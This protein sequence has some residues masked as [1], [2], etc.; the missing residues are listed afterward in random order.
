METTAIET[1][2][3]TTTEDYERILSAAETAATSLARTDPSRRAQILRS[4]ADALDA[5]GAELVPLAAA[6]SSLP[7]A[8]LRG[9]V[10]RTTMQLRM[11]ADVVE[12][13]SW[14]EAIIDTADPDALP[15][16]RP[17]LRRM[18]VPTGPAAVFGASNFPFAFGL[19]GGDTASAL[20]AGCPVVAK[21]HP[22][23]PRLTAAYARAIDEGLRAGGAPDGTFGVV[24]G[25]DVGRL[26]VQDPRITAVGFTG[27]T[28]G[29]RALADLAAGRPYPIPFYGELGSINPVFVTPAAAAERSGKIAGQFLESLLLGAGQF[30]TKPGILFV[31]DQSS[32]EWLVRTAVADDSFRLLHRGIRQSFLDVSREILEHPDVRPVSSP[33]QSDLDDL[34]VRPVIGVTDA[35]ALHRNS[36]ALIKECFGPF[37]LIVTYTSV[38]ELH[39]TMAVLPGTLTATVHGTDDDHDAAALLDALARY[40]GRVIWNGWPTGV[41][42]SWAQHHGGPYPATN[43]V[44]TSVGATAIRRFLRPVAYQSVH[45]AHL[46]PALVDANPWGIPRRVNGHLS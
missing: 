14:L 40:A 16:P 42:V 20:A 17:D 25:A 6:D 19:G 41:A 36:Q 43:S 21:A 32:I 13:G 45:E 33:E 12:E 1:L 39:A 34:S 38:A 24:Q 7:E 15:A 8:R 27:S 37:G 2:P 28:S 11:F 4:M 23:Q 10:S 18:L 31:P 3:D 30:C 35:R 5:N 46:P 22:A 44:H 29:G 26:L 9:E